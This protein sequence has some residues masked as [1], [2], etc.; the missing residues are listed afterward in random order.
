MGEKA[1]RIL[2]VED[3]VDDARLMQLTLNEGAR[4]QF[5]LT[6][7]ERLDA[8][9]KTLK[10]Q[11]FDLVLLDLSLPDCC[12]LDTFFK[13]HNQTPS[14]PVVVLTGLDDEKTAIAAAKGGAQ[15]YLVKGQFNRNLLARAIRYAIE[16]KRAEVE[17]ANYAHQMRLR[18]ELMQADLDLAR[19][20]QMALLPQ[21]FPV[22]PHGVAPEDSALTF[23]G[24]YEPATWL[25]GDYYDVFALSDSAAGVLVCDVMGHGVRAGLLTAIIRALMEELTAPG[26]GADPGRLLTEIN[27]GL[28][29]ISKQAGTALFV[30]AS[31]L[32]ADVAR[33]QFRYA[34]AGHPNPL[35]VRRHL[36]TVERLGQDTEPGPALGV[37]GDAVFK[38]FEQ[39][40]APSDLAILFTDGL[41]QAEGPDGGIYGAN[42]LLEAAQKHL[43]LPANGLFDAL[44]AEVRQY[45]HQ[46]QLTNDVC[47]VG[48]EVARIG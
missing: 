5:D 3:E 19:E 11:A 44:L 12:G 48:V 47:L 20:V 35:H 16:R 31:Y 23:C 1:I 9:L 7:V 36:N 25:G 18:N 43:S 45:S 8:A 28:S 17:L 26:G 40:M 2:L 24:R 39:P 37:F 29:V 14:T 6:H 13:L 34:I 10:E 46:R 32:V 15:D 42:R 41:F 30:T 33:G 22:F 38:T 4:D 27:R 21:Q